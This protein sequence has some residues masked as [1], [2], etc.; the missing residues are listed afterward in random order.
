[1]YRASRDIGSGYME[2]VAV[3]RCFGMMS[4]VEMGVPGWL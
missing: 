3:V 1:M 2:G 4:T